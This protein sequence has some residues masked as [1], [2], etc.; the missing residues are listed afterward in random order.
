MNIFTNGFLAYHIEVKVS[1][2]QAE[3]VKKVVKEWQSD[4]RSNTVWPGF[5]ESMIKKLTALSEVVHVD[6][7]GPQSSVL[8]PLRMVHGVTGLTCTMSTVL[9]TGPVTKAI[10]NS[11]EKWNMGLD[12]SRRLDD[13]DSPIEFSFRDT[14]GDSSSLIIYPKTRTRYRASIGKFAQYPDHLI[15]N[16]YNQGLSKLAG[17][18]SIESGFVSFRPR[19]L[20]RY[21][22]IENYI[23]LLPF[24]NQLILSSRHRIMEMFAKFAGINTGRSWPENL[25]CLLDSNITLLASWLMRKMP[26]KAIVVFNRYQTGDTIFFVANQEPVVIE[27]PEGFGNESRAA[28][29][30]GALLGL[31]L[32]RNS[33]PYLPV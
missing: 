11:F 16:R 23:S 4:F 2:G 1:S 17:Q 14:K 26:S 6:L 32:K 30:Q 21:D 33:S 25:E 12:N 15:L 5:P 28:R 29:L 8:I 9:G 7:E 19:E 20:G 22:K 27:A 24:T 31:M 10:E 3:T 13:A 18:V